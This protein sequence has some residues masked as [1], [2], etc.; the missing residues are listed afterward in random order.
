MNPIVTKELAKFRIVEF[1]V[2]RLF[3]TASR[4]SST[5]LGVKRDGKTNL[6]CW[7]LVYSHRQRVH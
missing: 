3:L 5:V 2:N 1:P 7:Q 4:L 6:A